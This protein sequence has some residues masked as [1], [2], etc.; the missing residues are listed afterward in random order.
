MKRGKEG[1]IFGLVGFLDNSF[2][3]LSNFFFN[4]KSLIVMYYYNINCYW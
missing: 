1:N 3:F 2:F 4:L